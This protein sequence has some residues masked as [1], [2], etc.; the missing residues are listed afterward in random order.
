[1][2]GALNEE[3]PGPLNRLALSRGPPSG[4]TILGE[5]SGWQSQLCRFPTGGEAA[6]KDE[7]SIKALRCFELLGGISL[8][9]AR[10]VFS[11][12]NLQPR[13]H[14]AVCNHFYWGTEAQIQPKGLKNV[15]TVLMY[16]CPHAAGQRALARVTPLCPKRIQGLQTQALSKDHLFT[17]LLKEPPLPQ[18]PRAGVNKS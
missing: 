17:L 12:S 8:P 1:M 7:L 14:L 15:M 18:P 4:A 13:G 10:P 9:S 2:G 11:P 6:L 16:L 3:Q 5:A